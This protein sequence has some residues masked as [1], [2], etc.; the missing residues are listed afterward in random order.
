MRAGTRQRVNI[1]VGGGFVLAFAGG[2]IGSAAE[3]DP[4]ATWVALIGVLLVLAGAALYVRGCCASATGKGYPWAVGLA[5]LAGLIGLL[6][7]VLLPDRY[8]CCDAAGPDCTHDVEALR[9]P[10]DWS[11]RAA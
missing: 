7:L 6:V 9:K 11:S 2:G 4:S 3:G 1:G 5:G 10:K 8:K